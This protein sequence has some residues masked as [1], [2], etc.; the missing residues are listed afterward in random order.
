MTLAEPPQDGCYIA[1]KQGSDASAR[2]VYNSEEQRKQV[3]SYVQHRIAGELTRRKKIMPAR[4]PRS[5]LCV[6]V[7][8]MSQYGNGC[9]ASSAAT[10]PL[11][12]HCQLQCEP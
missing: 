1:Y 3:P 9:A 2:A 8:T 4:G 7:V 5:D 12:A 11:R 6:V 10:R